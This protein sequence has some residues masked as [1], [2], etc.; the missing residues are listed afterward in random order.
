MR[1]LKEIL[2]RKI[3]TPRERLEKERQEFKDEVNK[4]FLNILKEAIKK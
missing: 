3:I 4:A 2:D 1:I